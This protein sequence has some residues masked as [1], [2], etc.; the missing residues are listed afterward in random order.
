MTESSTLGVLTL[1]EVDVG[2]E[3]G[4]VGLVGE[5]ETGGKRLLLHVE[6]EP[7]LQALV[8]GVALRGRQSAEGFRVHL[9]RL[10]EILSHHA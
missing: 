7:D 1:D 5:V 2:L 9:S 6:I 10:V 8:T 4:D 3:V